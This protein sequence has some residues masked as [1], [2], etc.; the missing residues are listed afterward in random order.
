VIAL[1]I[2]GVVAGLCFLMC[3]GF[4]AFQLFAVRSAYTTMPSVSAAKSIPTTFGP[5]P[6]PDEMEAADIYQGDAAARGLDPV[7]QLF[8]KM[9]E[10]RY[11]EINE[12]DQARKL[13]DYL[14]DEGVVPDQ[15]GVT[16]QLVE[17]F[18]TYQVRFC[19]KPGAADDANV[20]NAYRKLRADIQ[21]ADVFP[22]GI[23]VEFHLCDANMNTLQVLGN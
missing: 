5:P 3:G 23:A 7:N 9:S 17:Q 13:G 19:V 11:V 20:V 18:G 16:V 10:V 2:G 14:D 4:V 6:P 21:T 1:V 22:P 15:R 12:Q 8:Y